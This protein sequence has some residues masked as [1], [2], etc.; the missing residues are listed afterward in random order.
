MK[1]IITEVWE[2]T[3]DVNQGVYDMD[4]FECGSQYDIELLNAINR[5][6]ESM[7]NCEYFDT[8]EFTYSTDKLNNC[9]IRDFKYPSVI[10]GAII[11]IYQ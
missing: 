11:I 10:D 2:G 3:P 4:L 9:R 8:N 1:V 7:Y 6:L 5:A